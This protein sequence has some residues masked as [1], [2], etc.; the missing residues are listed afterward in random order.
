MSDV[1]QLAGVGTMTVSRVLSGTVSVSADTAKRV[2]TAIKE[3]NYRPNA[4][5]RAFRGQRSHSIGLIL[6]YLFDPFFANCAHAVTVV[7]K[8]HGYSVMITTSDEDPDSEFA[9]AEQMLERHVDG[10]IVIPTKFRETRLTLNL[11]G[12]TPVVAF[13]RPLPDPAIDVVLVQNTS[14]A[15]RIVEHLIEHGH[16]RILFMGLSRSLFTINARFL[17]YHRAMQSAGLKEDAFFGCGNEEDTTQALS[18][19][20][21][22]ANA[23][24]AIFTSNTLVTRFVLSSI[25]RLGLRVPN[26]LAFAGFD[27]FE[28]AEFTSPPLTVVRQPALEMGRVATNLLFDRI[29]RN[30]TS[31]T[32][33][34]IV[35]PVEIVLRRSCGC[36][37]RT[38][39]II[40]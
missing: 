21:K 10:L 4:L 1:A 11:F 17:G 22:G 29:E 39:M 30:E 18:E 7:A 20:L 8:Q 3:L 2:Q 35:L 34:R 5:A 16:Q 23:P 31:H 14:G 6:P 12:K 15:R 40:R 36:K 25:M 33:N 19:K 32:G 26:D 38:P 37:H 24:T 13:D 28:G 9:G 27:D